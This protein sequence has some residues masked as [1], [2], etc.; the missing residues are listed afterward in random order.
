MKSG[1][2]LTLWGFLPELWPVPPLQES[3]VQIHSHDRLD[4]DLT[5]FRGRIALLNTRNDRPVRVRLRFQNPTSADGKLEHFDLTIHEKGGEMVIDR[6]TFFPFTERFFKDPKHANRVGPAAMMAV[7]VTKGDAYFSAQDLTYRL[8][9]P[10][11][12]SP[13]LVVWDSFKGMSG[14]HPL[15]KLP[16]AL[17][18]NPP[19]PEGMDIKIRADMLRARDAIGTD[20]SGKNLDVVLA[21]AVTGTNSTKA[22][23]AVRCFAAV[24]DVASLLDAMVQEDASDARKFGDVRLAAIQ[25]MQS[26]ISYYRDGEY[27]LYDILK[28][29]YRP[30]QADIIMELLHGTYYTAEAMGRPETYEILI[31]YLTNDVL[32]IRELAALHL[33]RLVPA[34]RHI[35]YSPVASAQDRQNAQDSWSKLIPSGKLPPQPKTPT[36]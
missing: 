4:L 29:K 14:P 23:L 33:Y 19:V 17:S 24:D 9:E 12:G 27:K 3:F 32:P 31:H 15:D 1:V 36:K 5:L 16:D 21:E 25:S 22:R 34:G 11:K 8:E 30:G 13:T 6:W 26:W 20:L 7:V 18:S 10:G 35:R 28:K 2:R